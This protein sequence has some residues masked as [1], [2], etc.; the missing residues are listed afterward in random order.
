MP[1]ANL[2]HLFIRPLREIGAKYLVTGSIASIVYGEPRLTHDLD[3][4]I[5]LDQGQIQKT[6]GGVSRVRLLLSSPGG[7]HF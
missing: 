1:E 7:D 3:L 6:A 2:A 4:V 5:F